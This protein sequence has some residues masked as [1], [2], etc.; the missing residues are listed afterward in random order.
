MRVRGGGRCRKCIRYSVMQT[1]AHRRATEHRMA[2]FKL[3]DNYRQISKEEKY[4]KNHCRPIP[5]CNFCLL[6][7]SPGPNSISK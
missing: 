2:W 5:V 6:H 7:Y 1:A 3:I 4:S